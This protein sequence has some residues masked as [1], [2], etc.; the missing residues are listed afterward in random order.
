[1]AVTLSVV[2][3]QQKPIYRPFSYLRKIITNVN[4]V[5]NAD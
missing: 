3:E 4:H 5:R 1:M 2:L